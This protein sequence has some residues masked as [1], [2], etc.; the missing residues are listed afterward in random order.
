MYCLLYTCLPYIVRS[1]SF[2]RSTSPLFIT[3]VTQH[4]LYTRCAYIVSMQ[5]RYWLMHSAPVGTSSMDHE[6]RAYIA[7]GDFIKFHKLIKYH[8]REIT[9]CYWNQRGAVCRGNEHPKALAPK[10]QAEKCTDRSTRGAHFFAREKASFSQIHGCK[11]LQISSEFEVHHWSSFLFIEA[12][13][14]I[15]LRWDTIAFAKT[16]GEWKWW[17]Y[18]KEKQLWIA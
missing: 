9:L 1:W 15:K 14:V 8:L 10:R 13:F 4:Y 5:L 6:M 3:K 12:D 17:N 16:S 11:F 2:A 7:I 18:W